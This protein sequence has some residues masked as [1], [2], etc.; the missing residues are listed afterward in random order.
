[1]FF[2]VHIHVFV[3]L[4]GATWSTNHKLVITVL[5]ECLQCLTDTMLQVCDVSIQSSKI[6]F[7]YLVTGRSLMFR[8]L[9]QQ[10]VTNKGMSSYAVMRCAT[11]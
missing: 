11:K 10:A 8:N 5:H 4:F 7:W 2:N 6:D 3:F 1:M 9:N